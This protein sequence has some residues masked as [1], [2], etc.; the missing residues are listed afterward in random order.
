MILNQKIII[1]I[2]LFARINNNNIVDTRVKTNL[3]KIASTRQILLKFFNI[4]PNEF[5]SL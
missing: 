1:R 4:V 5:K 2:A 3:L